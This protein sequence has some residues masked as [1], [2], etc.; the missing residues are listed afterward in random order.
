MRVSE[1]AT[2]HM[3]FD[4]LAD[5]RTALDSRLVCVQHSPVTLLYMH[6]LV[7]ETR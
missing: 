2:Y 6:T 5:S 1:V 3:L 7:S 4:H